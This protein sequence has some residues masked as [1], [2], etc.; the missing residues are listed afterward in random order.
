MISLLKKFWRKIYFSADSYRRDVRFIHGIDPVLRFKFYVFFLVR[1]YLRSG[2][3]LPFPRR[4]LT[5]FFSLYDLLVF[6]RAIKNVRRFDARLAEMVDD[7]GILGVRAW[8]YGVFLSHYPQLKK[9][10]VLDVGPGS[11]TFSNYLA[12]MGSEVITI[13]LPTPMEK[14]VLSKDVKQVGGTVLHLPFSSASF[15]YTLA[16]S[17]LEHLDTDY[18]QGVQ[19]PS[20]DFVAD[21]VA[22]LKEMARVTRPGGVLY[23][24]TDAYLPQQKTDRWVTPISYNGVGGA[25]R[26]S[27]IESVF[28]G[29]LQQL[30]FV[31]LNKPT[32]E[33]SLLT[34]SAKHSNYRGRYITTFALMAQ[35]KK[36][37]TID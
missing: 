5:A 10:R 2:L 26:F 31:L 24:T 12:S 35:K 20:I 11:S 32:I 15:D 18:N 25:Y 29:T 8:E 4:K 16:I 28:V 37:D 27:D 21:T 19:R 33:V 23:I 1:E 3:L 30:G 14:S 7:L 9:C 17:T 34:K 13:D 22:A 6:S 36:S